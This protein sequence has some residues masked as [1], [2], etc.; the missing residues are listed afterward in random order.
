MRWVALHSVGGKEQRRFGID[1]ACAVPSLAARMQTPVLN[2]P[3]LPRP[4]SQRFLK[5]CEI[6]VSRVAHLYTPP[7]MRGTGLGKTLSTMREAMETSTWSPLEKYGCGTKNAHV[8]VWPSMTGPLGCIQAFT[9]PRSLIMGRIVRDAYKVSRV[10]LPKEDYVPV[11]RVSS[12]PQESIEYDKDIHIWTDGSADRNGHDDCTAGSAWI[13]DTQHSDKVSLTGSVLSNNIAEVAAIVLCLLA[14]QNAHVV[15]HTDS[16][17]VLG[18]LRGGLLAM[19]RDGWGDAPRHLNRGPPT[20][21]LQLLLYLLRDRMGRLNFVKAKAHDSD[22]MNN[23][24]DLL[25]NEGHKTGRVFDI[26]TIQ[27]PAGWV[28]TPP[29]LCHQP[30][31]YLTKLTVRAMVQAPTGTLKFGVFSD[32][33]VVTIGNMFGIVLDPGN[34]VGKVWSLTIPEGLK[35]V[36]WKEMNGA[37]VLGHRYYGTGLVKSDLGRFCMCGNEMSLQ[38][39]L[40]GCGS[41]RLQPL[42]ELLLKALQEVSPA[43]CFKTLHPDEWGWSPWYPL[44]ALKEIEETTLPIFKG[45]KA[46]LKALKK[47]RQKREW[48]IGNYYWALW[49][50]RMKEIHEDTFKFVPS[51]CGSLLK[52]ILLTPVP[53]HLLVQEAEGGEVHEATNAKV[54]L[55]D[56][57]FG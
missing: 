6:G 22:V 54:R 27:I 52:D 18:L 28:D 11:A 20:P 35:E 45:R 44:L 5:I 55:T 42:L 48:I 36:L 26:N 25:A 47:T 53:A 2:H 14:W 46:V 7:P 16:T 8:N 4:S 30:L 3:A 51:L 23:M 9:A 43:N 15:I 32:R 24:A 41:Y 29:V 57:A 50:W 17:Y 34:H 31:N 39:I 12:R 21:L 38:H 33:W 1:L 49:K 19:E 40:L 37:Q 56:G 10:R 13:S